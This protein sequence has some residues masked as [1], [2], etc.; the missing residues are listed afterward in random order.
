MGAVWVGAGAGGWVGGWEMARV[1]H[2]ET[3]GIRVIVVGITKSVCSFWG[4]TV[5]YV[6]SVYDM[7]GR[8]LGGGGDGGVEASWQNDLNMGPW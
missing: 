8:V 6:P 4:L 3:E 1:W 2:A 5:K 7:G